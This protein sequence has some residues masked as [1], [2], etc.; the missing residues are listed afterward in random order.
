MKKINPKCPEC[1]ASMDTGYVIDRS[2]NS[3]KPATWIAGKP[4]RNWLTGTKIK[5][6]VQ[7]EVE[8]LRCKRCG[9][10]KFYAG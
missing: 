4:E 3:I 8:A 9:L 5:G 1:G 7:H 10:L 2:Q 6:K